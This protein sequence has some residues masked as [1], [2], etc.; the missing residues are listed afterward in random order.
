MKATSELEKIL[1]IRYIHGIIA[2]LKSRRKSYFYFHETFL[3]ITTELKYGCNVIRM[4]SFPYFVLY[5]CL[6]KKKKKVLA[7]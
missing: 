1:D 5:I 7:R 4:V 3:C 6:L 2:Y